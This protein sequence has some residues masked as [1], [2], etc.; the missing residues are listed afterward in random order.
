MESI[1]HYMQFH[2]QDENLRDVY[3]EYW[4]RLLQAYSTLN[5]ED[6][7]G[8][9]NPFLLKISPAYRH[10][11]KKVLFVG[12]EPNGWDSFRDTLNSF[13]YASREDDREAIHDYLQWMY[14]DFR[15]RRSS[16]NT[17]YWRGIRRLFQAISPKDGD[18]AFLN[19]QLVRMDFETK[20]LPRQLEELLQGEFNVLPMEIE[21]LAPDVVIFVT[22]PDYDMRLRKTFE[23]VYK[24][25]DH[26]R[27]EE[28]PGLPFHSLARLEHPYLPYFPTHTY[29]TYHPGYSLFND[30]KVFSPIEKALQQLCQH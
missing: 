18:D 24:T 3:R 29:R 22:G 17:L 14:E 20:R 5:D 15:F 1:A 25:G 12:Q 9:S 26:L 6:Q 30:K 13:S 21:A 19:T 8:L 16:D 4:W 28:V 10:A 11:K 27:F 7:A 23:N 2:R